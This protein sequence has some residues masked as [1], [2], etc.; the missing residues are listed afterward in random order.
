MAWLAI[1]K[2]AVYELPMDMADDRPPKWRAYVERLDALLAQGRRGDAFEL[3][4][5]L[6]GSSVAD[7]A[8]A[9]APRC[10]P[11]WRPS[12]TRSPTTPRA[13]GTADRSLIAWPR[14]GGR[15]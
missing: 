7:V 2:L 10:G 6:A 13:C 14:S 4:M 11:P 9:R 1:G 12:L 15:H 3:F 5:R 8:G